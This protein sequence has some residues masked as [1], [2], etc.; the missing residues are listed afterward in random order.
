MRWCVMPLASSAKSSMD[1]GFISRWS[2]Q[3]LSQL[4]SIWL[5]VHEV[6]IYRCHR[7]FCRILSIVCC[8]LSL[9]ILWSEMMLATNWTSPIGLLIKSNS[10][11][12]S[13]SSAFIQ[14]V[15]FFSLSYISICTYWSLFR[16]NLGYAY[17]LQGPNQTTHSSLIFNAE[18]FSRLQFTLGYNFL[19]I[20][21]SN[22]T[23]NTAFKAL[24][25]NIELIPV[26][27]S[28]FL[29]YVPIII[30]LVS[31]VTLFNGFARLSRL[32]GI[33]TE[34]LSSSKIFFCQKVEVLEE[35]REQYN[36]GTSVV[37]TELK[38]LNPDMDDSNRSTNSTSR[39]TKD[40]KVQSDRLEARRTRHEIEMGRY[41]PS[42]ADHAS[43]AVEEARKS[44]LFSGRGGGIGRNQGKYMHQKL[45]ADDSSHAGVDNDE[46]DDIETFTFKTLADDP[47]DSPPPQQ[48][49][50]SSWKLFGKGPELLPSYYPSSSSSSADA[51]SS[52]TAASYNSAQR[53]KSQSSYSNHIEY[54]DN[55]VIKKAS[56]NRPTASA[57][58]AINFRIDD[59]DEDESLGG[60]RYS[61]I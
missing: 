53:A 32:F 41:H 30:I 26:F 15:A 27:G 56:E 48:R 17:S 7:M 60:G 24:M 28:S 2:I 18:Y 43:E 40:P 5:T 20:L 1:Q 46:D 25:S 4:E 12:S 37:F 52:S 19:Q 22:R 11:T 31:L 57:S 61:G 54:T 50:E 3:F 8:G 55:P 59:D 10:D 45:A 13:N 21:N 29:V 9:I 51:S 35:D 49:K 23:K 36:A 39:L 38:R 44:G 33:E 42:S 34:E 58:N 16:V 14:L 47:N 6:W